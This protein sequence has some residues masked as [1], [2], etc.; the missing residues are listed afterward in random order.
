MPRYDAYAVGVNP[1]PAPRQLPPPPPPCPVK[2]EAKREAK[3][4]AK[5][6]IKKET[7]KVVDTWVN[8]GRLSA[9]EQCMYLQCNYKH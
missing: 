3:V 4:E 2:L 6:E 8:F 5:K 1:P 7:T 9:Q